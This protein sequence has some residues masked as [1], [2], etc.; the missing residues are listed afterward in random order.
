MARNGAIVHDND[1]RAY[2]A[3]NSSIDPADRRTFGPR[4]GRSPND[5]SVRPAISHPA[6]RTSS[7]PN[8]TVN[9]GRY[10]YSRFATGEMTSPTVPNT[11]TNPAVMAAVA[12]TA[13]RTARAWLGL[14]SPTI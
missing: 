5:G 2:A 14:S 3:P 7:S 4:A 9:H 6:S 8:P 12:P 11:A 13:R 10:R 1:A